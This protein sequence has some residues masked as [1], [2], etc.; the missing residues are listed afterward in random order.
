MY[1]EG[2]V[3]SCTRRVLLAHVQG[4]SCCTASMRRASHT[5]NIMELFKNK[6]RVK[7][8]YIITDIATCTATHRLG[9]PSCHSDP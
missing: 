9:L 8:S 4:G 6:K 1:K 7:R 2:A 5:L 3:G